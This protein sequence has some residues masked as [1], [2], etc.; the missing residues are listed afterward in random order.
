MLFLVVGA[1]PPHNK[2]KTE[3]FLIGGKENGKED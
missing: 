2:L 3:L 1:T